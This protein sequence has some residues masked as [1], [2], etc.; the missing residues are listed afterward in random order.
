MKYGNRQL[1]W[2]T[3]YMLRN[4]GCTSFEPYARKSDEQFEGPF[5]QYSCNPPQAWPVASNAVTSTATRNMATRMTSTV[6]TSVSACKC[7]YFPT[8]ENDQRHL[9]GSIACCSVVFR[10]SYFAACVLLTLVFAL[11][12]YR[13]RF[14]VSELWKVRTLFQIFPRKLKLGKLR[15]Y[16]SFILKIL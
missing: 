9:F 10:F 5:Q 14:Y 11:G 7:E 8:L 16:R 6:A 3:I 2:S 4:Y 13:D 1:E 15:L 12:L